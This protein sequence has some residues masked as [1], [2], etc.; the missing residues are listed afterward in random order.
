MSDNYSLML[1]M[2]TEYFS[3]GCKLACSILSLKT[4]KKYYIL[5]YVFPPNCLSAFVV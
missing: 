2:I 3:V 4:S 5:L 1:I